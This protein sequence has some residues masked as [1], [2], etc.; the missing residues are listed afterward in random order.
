MKIRLTKS[1]HLEILLFDL[2]NKLVP[3]FV[4]INCDL[5]TFSMCFA[6]LEC[7]LWILSMRIVYKFE[8][9]RDSLEES[10]YIAPESGVQSEF[11]FNFEFQSDVLQ[12]NASEF[13]HCD[14]EMILGI[15]NYLD[16]NTHH[17][18]SSWQI[19]NLKISFLSL[20]KV[21][22]FNLEWSSSTVS[23]LVNDTTNLPIFQVDFLAD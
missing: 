3:N 6:S 1:S 4:R 8:I 19:T 2:L 17:W 14:R 10:R 15:S 7:R 13:A 5:P 22:E 16:F 12:Q 11:E 18:A 23:V 20:I 21:N 9:P